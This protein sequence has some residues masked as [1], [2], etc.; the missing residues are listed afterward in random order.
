[1]APELRTNQR[2]QHVFFGTGSELQTSSL[3]LSSHTFSCITH[4]TTAHAFCTTFLLPREHSLLL[5]TSRT[6][7]LI[8]VFRKKR[9]T[10]IPPLIISN[11]CAERVADLHF[12]GVHIE[13][14]TW[15][16]N[17]SELL[18][19]A[20][21]RLHLLRAL[22]KSNITQRLLVSFYRCSIESMLTYCM[23]V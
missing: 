16:A 22:M 21:Q 9:K 11:N 23:S 15:S 18:R 5:N 7:E 10:D 12:P 2:V 8:I 17:T 3:L 4:T 1:M 20:Q 13:N 19:K 6:K 14:L